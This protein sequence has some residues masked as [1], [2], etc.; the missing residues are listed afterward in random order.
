MSKPKDIT[1]KRKDCF[2]YH[3]GMCTVLR[4]THFKNKACPFFKPKEK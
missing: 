3:K 2:A 1:C 4:D